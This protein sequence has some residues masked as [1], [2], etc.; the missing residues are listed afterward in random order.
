MTY[1]IAQDLTHAV[2]TAIQTSL[3]NLPDF[4]KVECKVSWFGGTT[5]G[6]RWSLSDIE[7]GKYLR[8]SINMPTL[9]A[10]AS[11]TRYEADTMTGFAIHEMGHNICTDL[12][13]WKEACSEG[14]EYAQILNAF[15][16]PR[17][18]LDLVSRNR[19]AGARKYLELL[20]EYCVD[21]SKQNGWHPA[22]PRS[23]SFSINT[24]AYVEMCGYEVPSADGLLDE[25]GM[26]APHIRMWADK[27]KLCKTTADA[28][29]LT[30][31][32]VAYYPQQQEEPDGQPDEGEGQEGDSNS[33]PIS[34]V[35]PVTCDVPPPPDADDADADA[36]ADANA[37]ADAD[38]D[39]DAELMHKVQQTL[40]KLMMLNSRHL[41]LSHLSKVSV[42][43]AVVVVS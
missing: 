15:E 26:L 22:N 30:K 20:T 19:F 36:D 8:S 5:A 25:A 17:M 43:M 12:E 24:L 21:Y 18:E 10:T 14:K 2:D 11:V 41:M 4:H 27:L 32:F 16:D 9:P 38:A 6:T 31:E 28:W 37:D 29:A 42:L 1:I 23:L 7:G 39:A 33:Q 34:D 35:R 40:M 13:V 3:R